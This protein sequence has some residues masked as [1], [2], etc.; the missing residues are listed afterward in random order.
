[1]FGSFAHIE[2]VKKKTIGTRCEPVDFLFFFSYSL[3]RPTI[4]NNDDSSSSSDRLFIS[5]LLACGNTHTLL[6]RMTWQSLSFVSLLANEHRHQ[7]LGIFS[8]LLFFFFC[9]WDSTIISKCNYTRFSFN[10]TSMKYKRKITKKKFEENWN[11]NQKK[12]L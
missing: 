8:L 4:I 5:C 2:S 9:Q 10:F 11:E 7:S 12:L 1:M 6:H 3:A